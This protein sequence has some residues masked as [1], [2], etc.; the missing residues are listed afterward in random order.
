MADQGQ[1]LEAA[2]VD[3]LDQVTWTCPDSVDSWLF[4]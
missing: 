3:P 2:P 1:D 4:A